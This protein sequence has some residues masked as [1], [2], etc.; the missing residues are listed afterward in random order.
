MKTQ[1][2]SM[3]RECIKIVSH[4]PEAVSNKCVF[5]PEISINDY[6]GLC[7]ASLCLCDGE[8]ECLCLYC[9]ILILGG[10]FFSFAL[11]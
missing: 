1:A 6:F 10:L 11:F 9:W 2:V 3:P 5:K 4:F 8:L 7:R